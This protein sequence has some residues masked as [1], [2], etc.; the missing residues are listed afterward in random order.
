M[1]KTLSLIS[2]LL[3]T[4]PL[5]AITIPRVYVQRLVLE[6]GSNPFVT[7]VDKHSAQ[8]YT[9]R[10]WM[11]ANPDEVIS[12]EEHPIHTIG[13]K[14]VGDDKQ[15]PKMVIV[16]V[17]LGNFKRQWEAGDILH[18]ALTHKES[19]ESKGWKLEIP[20][21]TNLIKKLDEPLIIPPYSQK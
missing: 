13:I 2:V 14:E 3:L 19:G 6:D 9:L 16:T 4:I 12:T 1:K 11:Q 20:E 17:Q 7:C 5:L 8:E 18:L 15:F 10:A 21:G